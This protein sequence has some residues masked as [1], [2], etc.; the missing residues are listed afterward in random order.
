MGFNST[1]KGLNYTVDEVWPEF[2]LR[3]V[4]LKFT[5]IWEE[6]TST[7]NNNKFAVPP[8]C[9]S[10]LISCYIFRSNCHHQVANIYIAKTDS[11]KTVLQCLFLSNVQI[12]VKV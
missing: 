7:Y 4:W 2:W 6:F 8:L 10:L 12:I 3:E 11:D 1:F 5:N 9:I